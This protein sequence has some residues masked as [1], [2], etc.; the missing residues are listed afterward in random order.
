M[1]TILHLIGIIGIVL[2]SLVGNAQISDYEICDVNSDGFG[3]FDLSTKIDE[4]LDGANASDYII[5]FHETYSD[6]QSNA[7]PII[8]P[9]FYNMIPYVQV[10]YVRIENLNDSTF[11]IDSFDLIV[12]SSPEIGQPI[13][14]FNSNGI[15][16]LTG[17][18]SAIY[19]GN[20]DLSVTFHLTYLN[21]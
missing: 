9:V 2:F 3:A 20:T 11:E 8:D 1:K 10:M 12:H 18:N 15:F 16:D 7:Y 13:N 17:N 4:I 21:A 19:N 14:L 5:T 6:A